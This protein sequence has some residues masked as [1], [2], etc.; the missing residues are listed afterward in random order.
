MPD[1]TSFATLL[2]RYSGVI[3]EIIVQYFHYWYQNRDK[4]DVADMDT[5]T[6]YCLEMLEAAFFLGL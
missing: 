6:E 5:P 3:L 4:D 2:T 1:G